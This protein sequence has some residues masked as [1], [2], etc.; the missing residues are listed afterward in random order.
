MVIV[1]PADAQ[2]TTC[3]ACNKPAAV[4]LV[5]KIKNWSR[6][7]ALCKRC[8]SQ[9]AQ[10]LSPTRVSKADLQRVWDM[11]SEM[12]G[13]NSYNVYDVDTGVRVGVI[14]PIALTLNRV[15]K[16]FGLRGKDVE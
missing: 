4:V 8:Q 3:H 2:N 14:R 7:T 10:K 16:A 11:A 15:K 6:T 1:K 5:L 12:S 13:E 9:A